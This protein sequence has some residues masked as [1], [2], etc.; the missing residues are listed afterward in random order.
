VCFSNAI[1]DRFF[2]QK[3]RDQKILSQVDTSEQERKNRRDE[4]AIEQLKLLLEA[5]KKGLRKKKLK[6]V[7]SSDESDVDTHNQ[8]ASRNRK[9]TS[10][11][12]ITCASDVNAA[13]P[14]HRSSLLVRR[15]KGASQRH[16]KTWDDAAG[17][18]KVL[19]KKSS[20][21]LGQGNP[22]KLLKSTVSLEKT[23]SPAPPLEPSS[24]AG[25]VVGDNH[26]SKGSFAVSQT[27]I[28]R[29]QPIDVALSETCLDLTVY[30]LNSSVFDI[31]TCERAFS[32]IIAFYFSRN[33]PGLAW[34]RLLQHGIEAAIARNV[35][36][37]RSFDCK[38][39]KALRCLRQY[40]VVDE[41]EFV[42]CENPGSTGHI[43][44]KLAL[45]FV[46]LL[47]NFD[48]HCNVADFVE[49]LDTVLDVYQAGQFFSEA[50]EAFALFRKAFVKKKNRARNLFVG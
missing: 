47:E 11:G 3:N 7:Y 20:D 43:V 34:D 31:G 18:K 44:D 35:F 13:T 19:V 50:C 14:P 4:Q 33:F 5:K 39:N 26:P 40:Q 36:G 10:T 2:S 17:Q 46:T 1:F 9:R 42:R 41:S 22:S 48:S 8:S 32:A 23:I 38:A 28:P 15:R 6:R 45:Q 29:T 16:G 49:R 37:D 21:S 24:S 27:E 30:C 25:S 12:K